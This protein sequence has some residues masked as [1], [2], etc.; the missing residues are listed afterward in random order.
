MRITDEARELHKSLKAKNVEITRE[1]ILEVLK[2]QSEIG[3][4]KLS[5][6]EPF[7]IYRVGTI[8][9]KLKHGKS[10][11][12]AEEP[13]GRAYATITFSFK[14]AP[15]IKKEAKDRIPKV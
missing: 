9:P 6:G 10:F 13:E 5:R 15:E 12:K 1:Q 14:V 7:E 2:T 11:F 8:T 3:Q 4:Y